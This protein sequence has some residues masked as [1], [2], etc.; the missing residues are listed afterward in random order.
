MRIGYA[1]SPL[2]MK[3][4][5]MAPVA[6]SN[7]LETEVMTATPQ[8]LQLMLIEAAIRMTSQARWHFEQKNVQAAFTPIVRAQQI[9]AELL[10]GLRTEDSKNGLAH[11]VAGVYVFIY[12]TLVAANLEHSVAK[13]D[14]ALRVL[15][16]ERETWR[17]V[18]EI[19][20]AESHEAAGDSMS[21]SL[22]TSFEA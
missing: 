8:R 4:L 7:Y 16:V 1:L 18:C 21:F 3:D 14:D 9:M 11:R 6:G 10:S 13:L 20:G 17:R 12:R 22:R 15:E 19:L 2:E 5:S